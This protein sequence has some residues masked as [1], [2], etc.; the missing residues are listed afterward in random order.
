M[1]KR[2]LRYLV[3]GFCVT[4]FV[5]LAW[6]FSVIFGIWLWSGIS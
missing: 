2:T 4:P 1:A 6:L 3:I 5:F